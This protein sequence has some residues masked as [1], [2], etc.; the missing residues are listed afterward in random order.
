[1][2]TVQEIKRAIEKLSLEDRAEVARFIHGWS[3]DEWDEQI[4][5]DAD[6]GRLN[7][8]LRKVEEDYRAGRLKDGP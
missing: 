6:A 5:A 7:D 3:D 8:L 4:K 1:M 2:T